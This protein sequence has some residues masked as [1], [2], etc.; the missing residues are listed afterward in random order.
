[1]S[2][3]GLLKMKQLAEQSGVSAGTIKH[4]LREGRLTVTALDRGTAWLDTGTFASL[5]Q[6]TEFVS[7]VEEWVDRRGVDEPIGGGV[8][9]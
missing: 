3:N 5:R 7:V 2:E 8:R 1:M 4:Y 6:A 9:S